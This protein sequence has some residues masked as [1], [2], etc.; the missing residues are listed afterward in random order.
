MKIFLKH[1]YLRTVVKTIIVSV[2][3]IFFIMA[4][5]KKI[6]AVFPPPEITK[7]KLVG[8]THYFGYPIYFDNMIFLLIIFLP[9]VIL[10]IFSFKKLFK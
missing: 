5:F 10:F 8:F 2:V 9:V 6:R 3:V 4:A 7:D 1:D